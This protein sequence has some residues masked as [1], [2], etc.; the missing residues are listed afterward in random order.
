MAHKYNL[1]V[2]YSK[3]SAN[4][5]RAVREQYTKQQGGNCMFCKTSLLEQPLAEVKKKKINWK[6]FPPGFLRYPVHLQHNH[7]NDLTEG[8]VHAYC[9][10]VL[11][12]YHGR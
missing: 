3:L 4:E 10:A 8:A 1:P 9:N 7:N 11:W 2:Y 5:K 6:L 12:Q